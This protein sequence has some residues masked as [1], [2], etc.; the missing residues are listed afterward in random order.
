MSGSPVM[1]NSFQHP[2]ATLVTSDPP[3]ADGLAWM[4]K[5]VQH[6]DVENGR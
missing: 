2:C 5:Q 4:L 6:D 1:L 3:G